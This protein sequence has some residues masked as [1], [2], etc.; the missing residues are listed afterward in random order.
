[1]GKHSNERW[2]VGVPELRRRARET[3]ENACAGQLHGASAAADAQADE[4]NEHGVDGRI[5][6]GVAGHVPGV[7]HNE[8]GVAR[9]GEERA[10]GQV[11]IEF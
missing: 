9:A 4:R 5:D 1:M 6:S 2:S 7:L 8:G 11:R 3:G 10:Q